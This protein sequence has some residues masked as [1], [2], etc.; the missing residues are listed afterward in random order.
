[1]GLTSKELR[2]LAFDFAEDLEIP[3]NFN[4]QSGNYLVYVHKNINF[5]LLATYEFTGMAE[6]VDK[7]FDLLEEINDKNQYPESRIWGVDETGVIVNP[8]TSSR[9]IAKKG[10]KQVGGKT[11]QDRGQ[12]VTAKICY[13]ATGVFMPP[14][15]IFPCINR[16]ESFLHGKPHGSSF[17]M[18]E[19]NAFQRKGAVVQM[20]NIFEIFGKAWKKAARIETAVSSFGK[21]GICPVDRTKFKDFFKISASPIATDSVGSVAS[22]I[23]T[24]PVEGLHLH[25]T[26]DTTPLNELTNS[27]KKY[28]DIICKKLFA[29]DVSSSSSEHSFAREKSPQSIKQPS[30]SIPLSTIMPLYSLLKSLIPPN[31]HENAE[32]SITRKKRSKEKIKEKAKI[33]E[34]RILETP[35]K[36]RANKRKADKMKSSK[37]PKKPKSEK[38]DEN[39]FIFEKSSNEMKCLDIDVSFQS[40][41]SQVTNVIQEDG[42]CLSSIQL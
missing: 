3:H 6:E 27:I 9:I 37:S 39:A 14:M 24:N 16:N 28:K 8:K 31:C 35:L 1:M 13:S 38:D 41:D 19:I 25:N 4:R 17:Y 11:S 7:F 32:N 2:K 21:T 12:T 10:I 40:I 15:L 18:E 30:I 33:K 22:P 42:G 26:T 20:K 29:N 34:D 23:A 5:Y 36:I